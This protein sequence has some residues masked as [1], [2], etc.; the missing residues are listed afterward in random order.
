MK[1]IV[2]ALAA[3]SAFG[4]MALATTIDTSKF[5]SSFE[6][7]KT[8][9]KVG[10][11]GTF[12]DAKYTFGKD[13]SSIKGQLTGAKAIFDPMSVE[14]EASAINLNMKNAFFGTFHKK[15]KIEVVFEKVTEGDKKGAITA[16]VKMNGRHTLVPL[17][18]EI[19]DGKIEA[20]GVLDLNSFHLDKSLKSLTKAAAG[21]KGLTWSQV[22][23][24]FEAPIK[25]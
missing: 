5:E 18:Y 10:V 20:K 16:K 13:E 6:G 25:E 24:K 12:K 11:T 9:E 23:I 1:K 19:E 2:L 14:M 21:H 8:M 15:E 7:F 17:E 22:E 4:A 3:F